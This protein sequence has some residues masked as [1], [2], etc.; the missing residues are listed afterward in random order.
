[1]VLSLAAYHIICQ[2]LW[3]HCYGTAIYGC[4]WNQ[5]TRVDDATADRGSRMDSEVYSAILSAQPNAAK[6]YCKSNPRVSQS[7]GK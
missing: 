3:R 6:P 1:M 2:I 4:Q 5:V 7:K